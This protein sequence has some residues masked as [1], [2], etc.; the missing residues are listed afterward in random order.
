M[1][2]Q[3]VPQLTKE[4]INKIS[5]LLEQIPLDK[6]LNGQ[7]LPSSENKIDLIINNT[8][9]ESPKDKKEQKMGNQHK[10][11]AS[12]DLDSWLDDLIG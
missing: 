11:T 8:E 2:K 10:N 4:Q 1:K 6:Q 3:A 12:K 7:F 5:S 9:K